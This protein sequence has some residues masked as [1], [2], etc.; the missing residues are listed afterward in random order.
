MAIVFDY[1]N[2][3]HHGHPLHPPKNPKSIKFIKPIGA[4]IWY[5]NGFVLAVSGTQDPGYQALSF[6]LWLLIASFF[7]FVSFRLSPFPSFHFSMPKCLLKCLRRFLSQIPSIISIII[8]T[9]LYIA[10]F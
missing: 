6:F 2:I 1:S 10:I 8:I 5:H 7:M 4:L 3:L 9:W